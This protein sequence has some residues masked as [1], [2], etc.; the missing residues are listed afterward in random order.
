M[1]LRNFTTSVT[2][3]LEMKIKHEYVVKRIL[4]ITGLSLFLVA[5]SKPRDLGQQYKDGVFEQVLNPVESVNSD[6]SKNHS[7]FPAQLEQVLANSPSLSH[8]HQ[9]VYIKV[10]NWLK[11]GADPKTLPQFGLSI[12]QMGGGDNY[13]NV[14]FTGY[15]SPVITLRR[16]PNAQYQYPVY[17]MPNCGGK[18]A[19]CPSRAAIYNGALEG[20]GLE[21]GYSDSMIDVF[22][23]EVQGSGF[24]KFTDSDEL[25]YFAYGGKNGHAYVSIGRLLIEQGEV[26][27]EKMSLQAIIDWAKRQPIEKVQA[28]L[29]QNP[30]YVFFSPQSSHDVKGSAGIPLL[31]G[32]SVA[33]DRDYLPMGSVILAE[34]PQ[35]NEQ[36][37]WNGLHILKLLMVLDTGGAVKGNH[38]DLY[39]GKGYEAGIKAGHHKH[40]GRVWHLT[41]R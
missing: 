16:T 33:A 7:L 39:H 41:S 35:L 40:F 22:I 26:E 24:V 15:F 18:V 29:V 17:R 6:K 21:L 2:L 8:K 32:A 38:L 14:L 11:S 9:A 20:Q 23:M 25:E 3:L 13:G 34:V 30:S 31:A 10:S 27:K 12:E 5:C 37:Q 36:G 19:A 4:L 1:S 28:L